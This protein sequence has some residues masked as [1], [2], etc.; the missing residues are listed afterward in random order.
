MCS[1]LISC[2]SGAGKDLCVS[3]DY[4]VVTA[5]PFVSKRH[6][7]RGMRRVVS[8]WPIWSRCYGANNGLNNRAKSNPCS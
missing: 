4:R 1:F 8:E 2:E 5:T 6:A 7:G 3:L